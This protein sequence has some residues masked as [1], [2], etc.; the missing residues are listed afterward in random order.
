LSLAVSAVTLAAQRGIVMPFADF[1]LTLRLE[2]ALSAYVHY[3]GKLFWPT[4]LALY[5]PQNQLYLPFGQLVG[6]TLLMAGISVAVVCQARRRPYLIV[7]WLWYVG[8]LVPVIGLVQVSNQGV[9]D[10]WAYVPSVGLVLML[11]WGGAEIA[12]RWHGREILVPVA[13]IAGLFF[14]VVTW[15]Q[16]QFW[17]NS[18]VVWE[19][20]LEVTENNALAHNH[21]GSAYLSQGDLEKA[22]QQFAEA[23]RIL[24][25]YADA[26]YNRGV[27]FFEQQQTEAAISSFAVALRLKPNHALAHQGMGTA[28]LRS[29]Q[30]QGALDHFNRCLEITPDSAAAYNGRG[31]C[32]EKLGNLGAAIDAYRQAVRL[33][34]TN[35]IYQ[36]NLTRALSVF[37][38]RAN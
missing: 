34:A 16:V 27:V 24:P 2:N 14:L 7:G 25:D 33:E 20:T 18:T 15:F 13:V 17:R 4:D 28:L 23:V 31:E 22:G 1:P 10:R 11:V 36:Q 12:D 35:R 38:Q 19:H 21:L 6:A 3:I 32:L 9:P 29:G 26:Q 8:T 5:Y 37:E 30:Y